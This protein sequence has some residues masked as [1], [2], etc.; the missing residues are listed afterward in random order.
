M[1]RPTRSL[2]DLQESLKSFAKIAEGNVWRG[3]NQLQINF[4]ADNPVKTGNVSENGSGG[5]TWASLLKVYGLW[6]DDGNVTITSAG[7]VIIEGRFFYQQVV[8][9]ILNFQLRSPYSEHQRLEP[10]FKIFPFRIILKMLLDKKINF[11]QK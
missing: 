7:R 4:E 3:N 11:L 6:Y 9:Q 2:L 10:T 8:H 1:P 5:R